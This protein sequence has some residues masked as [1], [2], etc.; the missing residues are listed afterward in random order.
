M[1][2]DKSKYLIMSRGVANNDK[3]NVEICL[4][5][6]ASHVWWSGKSLIHIVLIK[7]LKNDQEG[8]FVN[9]DR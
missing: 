4:K 8:D 5:L 2:K 7:N 6:N 1:N 3:P 9:N